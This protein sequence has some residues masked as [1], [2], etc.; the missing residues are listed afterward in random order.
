MSKNTERF[1]DR[2]DNYVKYRPG[3]P[4][5]V[6]KYLNESIDFNSNKVVADI[7]S[8]TGISAEMFLENG[9]KVYAVEPNNEMREAADKLLSR[10]PNYHSLAGTSESTTIVDRG[11]DLIVAAQSF[12]WFDRIAFKRECYR[13]SRVGAY[14][15]LIWNERK[16][17]SDFEK[18]YEALLLKYANDYRKVDHRNIRENDIE[19]F[20]APN[21]VFSETLHNEQIFDY[22]GVKGRLLSSSYA[23]NVGEPNFEPMI[24]YLRE[25]FD[26]YQKDGRVSFSYD[27]KLFLGQIV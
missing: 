2:V 1:S 23:P 26:K 16:V 21:L 11:I 25:I 22:E 3:Y 10:Y 19:V 9:N 4:S 18:A 8:G 24:V 6:L 7:G 13:I 20:F 5:E 15:L 12:H 27:C 17:M 14:C